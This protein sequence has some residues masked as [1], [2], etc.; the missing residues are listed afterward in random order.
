MPPVHSLFQ[1]SDTF[2]FSAMSPILCQNSVG[3]SRS[4]LAA[5]FQEK[6]RAGHAV[7]RPDGAAAREA[8]K[9]WE[10]VFL[11]CCMPSGALMQTSCT[12]VE[13]LAGHV[14]HR[15]GL[16]RR[17]ELLCHGHQEHLQLGMALLEV[18]GGTG[19]DVQKISAD[20]RAADRA[21]DAILC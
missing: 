14:P 10:A 13:C 18:P 2:L 9:G 8:A 4:R 16:H 17:R 12:T 21:H 5:S 1:N 11:A 20:R 6:L 7:A 15:R 19:A 3:V